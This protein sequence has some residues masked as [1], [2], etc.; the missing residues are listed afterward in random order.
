MHVVIYPRVTR[1]ADGAV[2]IEGLF[3]L[4]LAALAEVPDLIDKP[5]GDVR[6]RL[7][8]EPSDDATQKGDW[9]R[10]VRPELFALLASA[11]EILLRDLKGV[12]PAEPLGGVPR[13]NVM[14]PAQHVNA[15]ISA[16]N[17]AR[18]ALGAEHGVES[19]EDLHPKLEANEEGRIEV[20]ERTLA[21]IKIGA[22][23]DLQALLILDGLPESERP[24]RPEEEGPGEEE[25][26]PA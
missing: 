22:L 5:E 3:P 4:H 7:F 12:G 20:D 24:R 11:R 26:P 23:A 16:L 10:L 6:K 14:V 21:V 15:W 1:H 19:E 9:E 18:L 8:P 2:S 13:W 17:A 25:D